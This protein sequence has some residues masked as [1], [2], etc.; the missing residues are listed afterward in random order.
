MIPPTIDM[1]LKKIHNKFLLT[2]AISARAKEINQGSLPY[3]EDFNPNNSIYTA[4]NE[5]ASNKIK[6]KVLEGPPAKPLK[7]IE[8]KPR[9]FWTIDNLEKKEIRKAKKEK[10]SK[11]K[12]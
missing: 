9:D 12:K 6:I 4:M 3:V 2:N 1:L 11:K 8:E 7:A 5:L 10:K